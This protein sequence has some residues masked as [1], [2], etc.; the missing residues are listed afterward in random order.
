M[1]RRVGSADTEA[2]LPC[3]LTLPADEGLGGDNIDLGGGVVDMVVV[4][5]AVVAAVVEAMSVL[6]GWVRNDGRER[7]GVAGSGG[8]WILAGQKISGLA[9]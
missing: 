2:N 9:E 4:A 7:R 8:D 5:V 6:F 1:A 3:F